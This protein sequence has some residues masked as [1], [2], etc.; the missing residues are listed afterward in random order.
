MVNW[1]KNKK[2]VKLKFHFEKEKVI[3]SMKD[4]QLIISVSLGKQKN[5]T[6]KKIKN[7]V[8]KG[9]NIIKSLNLYEIDI[10]LG[11]I[12]ADKYFE[13][14]VG[15]ELGTYKYKGY[16]QKSSSKAVNISIIDDGSIDEE[17][18]ERK[19]N[20][21][22]GML[23]TKNWTN[24]P[25][26]KLTPEILSKKIKYTLTNVGCEVEILDKARIEKLKMNLINAIG[27]SSANE[28]KLVVVRYTGD[29]SS[30]KKIGLVGKGIT[31]DTGGYNLKTAEGLKY[32]KDDMAG[33]ATV[34]GI[35]HVIARNKLKI[36]VTAIMPLCENRL[37]NSSLIPGDVITSMNGKTVEIL[38]VD[39]EG[40]LILADAI[41]YAVRN[42][43][44][45]EIIDLATLT[46]SI[47]STFG[48]VYTGIFSNNAKLAKEISVAAKEMGEKIWR[49]PLDDEYK[50]KL[51]SQVADI[52]NIGGPTAGAIIGATFIEHFVEKIPWVH[53]DIAGT[54]FYPGKLSEYETG[55][56]TGAMV[57]TLYKYIETKVWQ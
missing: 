5:L 46:G 49:L 48:N 55:G 17:E 26:N 44:V 31:V 24:M 41:T 7:A 12:L 34:V 43:K 33:A 13:V 15:A 21:V 28:Q 39:A 19:K 10:E 8:A 47:V 22:K 14:I 54:D 16:H 1:T 51:V 23:L 38:N 25:G 20:I 53:L 40:R 2:S 37:S 11:E 29:P 45:D 50:E 18:W 3:Q 30:P 35:M 6:S 9:I 52:Q 4:E 32:T 42:E 27:N 56:A 57:P 36:N